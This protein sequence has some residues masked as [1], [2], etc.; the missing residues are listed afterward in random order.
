MLKMMIM[1]YDADADIHRKRPHLKEKSEHEFSQRQPNIQNVRKIEDVDILNG[2]IA[3]VG[4]IAGALLPETR[5]H[6]LP[7][8]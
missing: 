2:G 5:G 6:P 8:R 1:T 3:K 7:S 4:G